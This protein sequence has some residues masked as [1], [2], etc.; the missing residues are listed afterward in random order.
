MDDALVLRNRMAEI[1]Y[2]FTPNHAAS[3]LNDMLVIKESLQENPDQIEMLKALSEEERREL[4]RRL[5][6]EDG[7]SVSSKDLD[8]FIE[9]L[10]A[11]SDA[12]Y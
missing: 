5:A 12:D 1:G 8:D 7:I 6:A 9:L 2:E 4:R 11:V 3:I 10:E